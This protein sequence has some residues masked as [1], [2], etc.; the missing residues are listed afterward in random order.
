MCPLLSL[1][2]TLSAP[3][4]K[5]QLWFPCSLGTRTIC[6]SPG[7]SVSLPALPAAVA[8]DSCT[9]GGMCFNLLADIQLFAYLR[10]NSSQ[11]CLGGVALRKLCLM[12]KVDPIVNLL[13]ILDR[14]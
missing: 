11:R 2:V 7:V 8:L 10:V 5:L 12:G 14:V 9:N 6:T 1:D 4:V 3:L 13:H